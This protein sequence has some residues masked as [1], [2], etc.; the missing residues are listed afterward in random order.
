M[1]KIEAGPTVV[2]YRRSGDG[3]PLVLVHGTSVDGQTN[4][5]AVEPVFAARHTV[6][7]PDYGGCGQSTIPEGELSLD[8]LIDQVT[9]VIR[10]VGEPQVDLLGDSLGAVVAAG[11]AAT[12]PDLV[13]RLILV[14]GW[15]TSA[16]PRHQLVFETWSRLDA[17]SPELGTRY[18]ASLAISP[19]ALTSLGEANVRQLIF[20]DPPAGT[21]QRIRLGLRVDLLDAL[22]QITAPTLV[23]SG[24]QDYVIPGY[25]V[26]RLAE[27]I[28]GSTMVELDMGHGAFF[29]NADEIAALTEEFLQ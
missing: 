16:D 20:Q 12:H 24:R 26:R 11:L 15:A 5:A 27:G 8:T 14:C 3:P 2:T 23:L 19:Q 17:I 28:T 18:I 29:E 10:D 21:G 13:R 25:Q 1:K 7:T 4:F 9:E 6:V 22:S